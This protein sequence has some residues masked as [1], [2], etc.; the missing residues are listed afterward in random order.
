M[1]V[2]NGLKDLL[3]YDCSFK[4]TE[5]LSL[6]NLIKEFNSI[7]Q[8]SYKE[9]TTLVLVHLVKSDDI[10]M[11]QILQDIDLVLQSDT[12]LLTHVKFIDDLDGTH[13]TSRFLLA[14]LDSTEGT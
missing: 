13:F 12:L 2:A 5:F 3:G 8:F 1:A 14:F 6:C 10:W 9:D 11:V 7:T 4:F